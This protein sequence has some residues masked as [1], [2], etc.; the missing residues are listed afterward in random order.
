MQKKTKEKWEK[1]LREAKY[2]EKIK[3]NMEKT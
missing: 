2:A 3:E 1:N